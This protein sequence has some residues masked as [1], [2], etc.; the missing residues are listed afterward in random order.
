M[1]PAP[2]QE[3]SISEE[4]IQQ[5]WRLKIFVKTDWRLHLFQVQ[6]AR[7]FHFG[8]PSLGS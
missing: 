3:K 2:S 1:I 8:L 4:R 7:A 5:L 6:K